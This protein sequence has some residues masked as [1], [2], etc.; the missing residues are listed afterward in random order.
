VVAKIRE[1]LQKAIAL[2]PDFPE[3][4]KLLAF[5][6]AVTG[7]GVDEAIASMKRV[8]NVV[9]GRRDF[10]IMLAQ[11][12]LRKEDFKTARGLLEQVVQMNASDDERQQA[13]QL[14]KQIGSYETAL[15]QYED[16]KKRGGGRSE[17]IVVS[18]GPDSGQSAPQEPTDPSSYLR[19]VLRKPKPDETQLQAKLVKIECEAKGIVFVVQTATGLLRLRTKTFDDVDI[20]TY[21]PKVNGEITCGP[22]KAQAAVVVCY[23]PG[24]DKRAKVDGILKSVEF[25]PADFKLK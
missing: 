23:V 19:E 24:V 25:V 11:L 9:R 18:T 13:E 7:E 16:L 3:S 17:S 21:D 1:H 6:S 14:L 12:Y 10:M 15:A 2:R 20:T 22:W 4:Y 8:L 5:V